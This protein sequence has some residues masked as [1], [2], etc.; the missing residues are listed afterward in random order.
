MFKSN[1]QYKLEIG[2]SVNVSLYSHSLCKIYAQMYFAFE[3]IFLASSSGFQQ[4]IKEYTFYLNIYDPI[5]C[6]H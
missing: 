4:Q 3:H 2:Y 6:V 1:N 5:T